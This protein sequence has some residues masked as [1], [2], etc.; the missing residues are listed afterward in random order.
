MILKVREGSGIG[1]VRRVVAKRGMTL[2]GVEAEK[3][4]ETETGIGEDEQSE[5]FS[6]LVFL[7]IQVERFEMK[8]CPCSWSRVGCHE[9]DSVF[10][11]MKE[12]I[13]FHSLYKPPRGNLFLVK[14][15]QMC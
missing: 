5:L 7:R 15:Y 14:L 12:E 3:E 10:T 2:T 4:K 11:V 8:R 1:N 9:K 13:S 6:G